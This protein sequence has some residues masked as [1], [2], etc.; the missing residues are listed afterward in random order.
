MKK[1]LCLLAVLV[2][3]GCETPSQNVYDY[4]EAGRSVIVQFGTVVDVR[5]V[6]IKGPNTGAGA[7]VGAVAGAT[8][9]A[10]VGSGDGQVAG[11]LVGVVAGAV[12][13]AMAEQAM[14]DKVG[15]EFTIVTEKGKTLTIVQ[16][17][18]KDEPIIKV[19]ERVMV[20]TSGSYQR[21][22]PADHLPEEIKRPKGIKVV[23]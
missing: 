10:N 15:R 4:R 20:Q 17:F 3:A 2:L 22:L 19:N 16:Y 7:G 5:E 23:D 12:A 21:V 8:A 11:A 1:F 14:Q 13:G 18:K 6:K 9:G